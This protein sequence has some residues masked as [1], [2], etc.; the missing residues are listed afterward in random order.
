METD[1]KTRSL[2]DHKANIDLNLEYSQNYTA[3]LTQ[4]VVLSAIS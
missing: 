2:A 3:E 4:P 1:P